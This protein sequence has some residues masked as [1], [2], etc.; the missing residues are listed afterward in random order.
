MILANQQVPHLRLEKQ[1]TKSVPEQFL[2][3]T[4]VIAQPR[5]Q[6]RFAMRADFSSVHD[7]RRCSLCSGVHKGPIKQT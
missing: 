3:T 2:V 6:V 7:E 1:S 4:Q 5:A